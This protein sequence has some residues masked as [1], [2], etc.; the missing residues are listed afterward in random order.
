MAAEALKEHR[1]G[2]TLDLEEVLNEPDEA[3]G[4]A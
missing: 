1:A 3:D 4:A 2:L